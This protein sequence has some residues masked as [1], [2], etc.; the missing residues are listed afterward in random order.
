MKNENRF[1]SQLIKEIRSHIPDGYV[2]KNAEGDVVT[3]WFTITDERKV[4]GTLTVE[5]RSIRPAKVTLDNTLL[6]Y[7]KTERTVSIESVTLDGYPLQEGVD[8]T[9]SGDLWGKDA[10]PYTEP[11]TVI[12]TGK[13]DGDTDG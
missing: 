8:Y 4:K 2:I 6:T 1:Q 9:V 11:Y 3:D 13:G 12:V 5:K 7:N 10:K